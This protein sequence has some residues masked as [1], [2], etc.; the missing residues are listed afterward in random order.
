MIRTQCTASSFLCLCSMTSDLWPNLTSS[1]LSQNALATKTWRKSVK[2]YQRYQWKNR[3]NGIL[4]YFVT[5]W[6]VPLTSWPKNLIS[7][8]LS[9]DT[10]SKFGENPTMQNGDIAE[11]TSWME[12][13]TR[14]H[15]RMTWK[16]NDVSG[17]A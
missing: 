1:S 17:T 5:L 15:R 11:T 9:Q 4:A 6:P 10:K 7:S 14:L 8:S 3:K 13:L 2:A 16:H 12:T